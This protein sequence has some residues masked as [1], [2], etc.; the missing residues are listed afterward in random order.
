MKHIPLW[1][2]CK[3]GNSFGLWADEPMSC[4]VCRTVETLP[5]ARMLYDQW[6]PLSECDPTGIDKM[7][8]P[9]LNGWDV[10][11]VGARA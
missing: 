8:F 10:P 6:T 3:H 5:Q 9:M 11:T 4:R 7:D 2:E 1:H